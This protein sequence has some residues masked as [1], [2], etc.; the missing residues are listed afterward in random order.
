MANSISKN[1][2]GRLGLYTGEGMAKKH[3]LDQSG[4]KS[5]REPLAVYYVKPGCRIE[6]RTRTDNYLDAT[7]YLSARCL[8]SQR[9]PGKLSSLVF[10]EHRDFLRTR[11][12]IAS[13]LEI[14]PGLTKRRPIGH[15]GP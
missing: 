7:T 3:R 5:D 12:D 15:V 8:G 1:P 9:Q 11:A 13:L 6:L 4:I 14:L 2:P 10:V